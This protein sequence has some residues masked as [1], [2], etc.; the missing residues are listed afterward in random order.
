MVYQ[1]DR[2][3]VRLKLRTQERVE[4]IGT[5]GCTLLPLLTELL[6]QLEQ[7]RRE[8]RAAANGGITDAEAY[9]HLRLLSVHERQ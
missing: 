3:A 5:E 1:A 2:P 6:K 7:V 8:L 4:E 9:A